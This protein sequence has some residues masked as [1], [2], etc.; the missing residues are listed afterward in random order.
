MLYQD[1]LEAII[2]LMKTRGVEFAAGLSD[3]EIS[4]I[5]QTCAF[6][7]PPDLKAF[8]Q[9]GMPLQWIPQDGWKPRTGFPNWREDPLTIVK[10][11]RQWVTEAFHFDI[12][13]AGFWMEAWGTR[14]E[15]LD[16][17]FKICDQFLQEAPLLIPIF[18]HRFLPALP[19]SA[20]NPVLSMWQA[21]DTIYYGYN[22]Q[23]YLKN[24]FVDD[25]EDWGEASDYR[26]V[27][28]WSQIVS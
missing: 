5:E 23:S 20:G 15:A 17:A 18:A 13:K 8:L 16:E 25:Q 28:F 26:E 4:T 6:Q 12:E 7:F 9:I 27:P 2:A 1:E 3:D 14:P 10:Q 11:S 24:E 22:L 21:V 19:H